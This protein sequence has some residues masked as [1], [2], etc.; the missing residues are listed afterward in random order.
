[1][2]LKVTTQYGITTRVQGPRETVVGAAALQRK[3]DML[4]KTGAKRAVQRGLNKGAQI[5][6]KSVKKAI[7]SRLKDARKAVGWRALKR[8]QNKNEPGVKIGAAVGKRG[9]KYY[10]T[11]KQKRSRPGVGIGLENIMWAYLG[12]ERR[13]TG[14]TRVSHKPGRSE[15]RLTGGAI[16]NTGKMPAIFDPVARTV[17]SPATIRTAVAAGTALGIAKEVAKMKK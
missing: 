6:L 12:T 16:R 14:S 15:R 17:G 2:A 3:L 7:P 1:M 13:S 10:S 8:S 11:A 9:K 5:A 4:S